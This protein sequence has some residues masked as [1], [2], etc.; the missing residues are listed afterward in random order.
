MTFNKKSFLK[1]ASF[2]VLI[3]C[4]IVAWLGFGERGFIHLYRMENE[5]RAYQKRIKDLE[6]ANNDL[7]DQIH[8]LRTDKEYIES[9]ARRELGL[10]KDNEKIYRVS[11][12][13]EKAAV[14][15]VKNEN[16]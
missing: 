6:S 5:R 15:D 14:G 13:P 3:L 8:R 11:Q 9:V 12:G 1:F 7:L 2:I 10:I 16:R 4:L